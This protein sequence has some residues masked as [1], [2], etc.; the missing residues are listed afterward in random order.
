[1]NLS[2]KLRNLIYRLRGIKQE[3]YHM[4]D[5]SLQSSYSVRVLHADGSVTDYGVVSRQVIT[6]IGAD[7]LSDCCTGSG[8]PENINWHQYGT[9]TTA[10]AI[11]DTGLQTPTGSRVAGTQ[12]NPSS[13]V[14]RSVATVPFTSNLAITEHGIFWTVAT[15]S[16][17][18]DRTVFAAINVVNGDS[19][20]GTYELTFADGG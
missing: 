14:Y 8:E 4:L 15:G 12:S 11:G 19:I 20:E 9:G 5:I 2:W 17:L 13:R 1:M 6:T 7:Y 18:F 10:A 3:L 16:T